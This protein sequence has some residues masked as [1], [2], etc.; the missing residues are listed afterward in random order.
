MAVWDK[1]CKLSIRRL[2]SFVSSL[3][4]FRMF[5]VESAYHP[6]EHEVLRALSVR[7]TTPL[8]ASSGLA[9]PRSILALG[10]WF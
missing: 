1:L 4:V 2:D 7:E 9:I 5:E 8:Q 3:D 10:R 6:S